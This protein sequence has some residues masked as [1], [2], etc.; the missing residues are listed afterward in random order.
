MTLE[1][2]SSTTRNDNYVIFEVNRDIIPPGTGLAYPS[3]ESAHNDTLAS[4]LFAING[5]VSVGIWGNSVQITKDEN[6]RWGSLKSKVMETIRAN[7][8]S[9]N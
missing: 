7:L 3:A 5:V 4:A 2:K 6:T 8:G 1:V 9:N